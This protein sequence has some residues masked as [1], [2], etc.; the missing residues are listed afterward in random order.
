M[1]PLITMKESEMSDDVNFNDASFQSFIE[2][3]RGRLAV[4]RHRLQGE[5]AALNGKLAEIDREFAAVAAYEAAKSGRG[6]RVPRTARGPRVRMGSRREAVMQALQAARREAPHALTR[7]E[8]FAATGAK[9]DFTV[10]VSISNA[11]S[12]LLKKGKIVRIGNLYYAPGDQD[13]QRD[14][15][16]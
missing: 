15:A 7:Q 14:A 10:E 1:I 13:E 16:E 12:A 11:M 6:P 5:M 2:W 8:I 9:G 3:E 4:E